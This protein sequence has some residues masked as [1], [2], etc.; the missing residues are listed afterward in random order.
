MHSRNAAGRR[1]ET[2]AGSF[3]AMV[4]V[5]LLSLVLPATSRSQ[6][7]E[8][9]VP[10]KAAVYSLAAQ[11]DSVLT[12]HGSFRFQAGDDAAWSDPNFDDS[13]WM[14][15]REIGTGRLTAFRI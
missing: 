2:I 8:A 15:V 7:V 10:A 1:T 14:L 11:R 3:C 13:H 6:T 4:L 12:L 5:V 9:P